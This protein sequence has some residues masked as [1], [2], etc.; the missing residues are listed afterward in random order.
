[1]LR[2]MR[3]S[4][5]TRLLG[6][7]LVF[8]GL[9]LGTGLAVNV[10]MQRQLRADVQSSDLAL[11]QAIALDVDGSLRSARESLTELSTLPE[12][13]RG[14]HAGMERAF[15]AFK[16]ARRDMDSVY[17]FDA[18]GILAVSVPTNARTLGSDF[19]KRRLF[20]DAS[21]ASGPIIEA[22]VVDLTTYNAVAAIAQPVRD[23][24]GRLTGVVALNLLL[25]NFSESLRAIVDE[26]AR[27]KNVINISL[28][29]A[30]GLL[31]AAPD[32]ERLLQPVLADLPGAAEALAGRPVTTL[33]AGPQQQNW[34]YSSVPLPSSGWAVVVQ[35]PASAALATATT[36]N[37]WLLVAALLFTVGGLLFWLDLLRLVIRPLQRLATAY[38]TLRPAD[39]VISM[40]M[41]MTMLAKRPDEV[42][43]LTRVLQRLEHDVATQFGELRTLLH[44]SQVV[45]GT[46]D[47]HKVAE[48]I[49]REVQRLVNV[50]AAA[51][52]VPDDAGMLRVLASAGRSERYN[53]AICLSPDDL[54]SATVRALREARPM[55]L[56]SDE[57]DLFPPLAY[58]E[59]FRALL[60]IPIMSPHTH[61]VVLVVHRTVPEPFSDN[62][63]NLLMTFANYAAL[64]WEHAVLYER[65]D[66]RLREEKQTLAAIMGSM[67]DGLVLASVDGEILY[68]NPGA[69][70]LLGCAPTD[71][72][73]IDDVHALLQAASAQ[74]DAYAQA[75]V[76]AETGLAPLWIVETNSTGPCQA[77]QL[78]LFDVHD[79]SGAV[80][81]RGLLLRD[82]TREQ[83]IDQFKTTLLG[84]VGHELRT[85][86]AVIKMHAS[87]LLQDDVLWSPDEQRQFVQEIN[88]EADR[89]AQLVGNL[90]DLSRLEAGL[91][92]LERT[93]CCLDDLVERAM[94]CL[95]E[96]VAQ[97]EIAIPPDLPPLDVD[98]PRVEVVLRNLLANGL[99]YGDGG[100]WIAAEQQGDMAV[101]RVT[102]DGPGIALDDLPHLFERFYRA[103]RGQQRRSSGIGLGLTICKAF[104]E[105]HGGTIW[106]ESSGSGATF[107]FSLPLHA[108][109]DVALDDPRR[110]VAM[111]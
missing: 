7:Y 19:S 20:Q 67:S 5:L 15:R 107:A 18:S 105:A 74:P 32:Q 73:Q 77:I 60:A 91:L 38:Q 95:H 25:D 47:P 14:D 80:I 51:V 88:D 75:R 26:Q 3:Q 27:Q 31:V 100:L 36:F 17:W 104:V 99:A 48:A 66:V 72:H 102:N 13:Q 69:T 2:S 21:A 22:G 4:L 106:A 62:E 82:V 24:Q 97:V 64:A 93:P 96:P 45:V 71:L 56:L 40:P 10:L 53:R 42:G 55:Q 68:A 101:V 84:A 23:A 37:T 44:T 78:R 52:F 39:G 108:G 50:Q 81:G 1:M 33:A 103:A 58:A 79:E 85:P 98:G 61:G 57:D 89:L 30:Q 109:M 9:V 83:E 12:V 43:G 111:A 59:G 76:Q 92:R 70:A 34:L 46:L 65:S 94:L 35:R 6:T 54:T 11:A 41:H 49:I 86:L 8:V 63:V 90:L 87:T 110:A 16:V 28:V 29:D